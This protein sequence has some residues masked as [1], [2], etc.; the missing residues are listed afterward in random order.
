MICSTV[1]AI[2]PNGADIA[3]LVE[4][5]IQFRWC[6]CVFGFVSARGVA[7]VG[8]CADFEQRTWTQSGRQQA[9]QT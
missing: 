3:V 6:T 7:F 1:V 4:L 8:L 9:L 5:R 2:M